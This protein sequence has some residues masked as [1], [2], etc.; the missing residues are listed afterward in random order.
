MSLRLLQVAQSCEALG[1]LVSLGPCGLMGRQE[2][3]ASS[4]GSGG[5]DAA[6]RDF[7]ITTA[8][9]VLEGE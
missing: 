6:S 2:A 3:P 4:T 1:M 8:D 7:C 5:A 9:K